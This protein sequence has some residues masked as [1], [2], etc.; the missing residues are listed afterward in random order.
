LEER[1]GA[2]SYALLMDARIKS[3]KE[4][5]AR[6]MVHKSNDASKQDAHIKL[7]IEEYM[8]SMCKCPTIL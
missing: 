3:S 1:E 8:S 7:R 4:E 6:G 2:E 5:C